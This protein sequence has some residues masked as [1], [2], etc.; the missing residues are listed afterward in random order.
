MP[1]V[2][3]RGMNLIVPE[4]DTEFLGYYE[5]ANANKLVVK[6]CKACNLLRWP[7]GS[8]CPWCMSLEWSWQE[9]SGK[10]TIYTYEIIVHSI[11][12]GFREFSPYPVIVVELDEQRGTPT[13][14]E[15]LRMVANLVDDNFQAEAEE[16]VAIGKRVQVIFQKINDEF[17]LPQFKLSGEPPEGPIWQFPS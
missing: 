10:G 6:R 17:T 9:V 13:E 3:Y 4:N 2:E 7:P 5:A 15:G 16:N 11:Q 14:H 12:P 1:S 8:A